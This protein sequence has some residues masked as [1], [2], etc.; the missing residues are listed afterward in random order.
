MLRLAE[1]KHHIAG[2][3]RLQIAPGK[4]DHVFFES[5]RK[6]LTQAPG[7]RDVEVKPSTAVV[8]V[9]Y[10]PA[11]FETFRRSLE[12]FARKDNLFVFAPAG[13]GLAAPHASATRRT[14]QS[15]SSF[16]DHIVQAGTGNLISLKE[17]V[18]LGILAWAL[19]FVDPALAA[20]QWLSWVAFAWAIY[21]DTHQDEPIQE[22]SQQ[23]KALQA[24]MALIRKLLE[25]SL[26]N[27][28]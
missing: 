26:H 12:E 14:I 27:Q 24:D 28:R 21:F 7:V 5:L 17:A 20:S 13:E 18:P 8:I 22:L 25:S 6:H 9:E 19:I 1:Q 2:R 10:D 16:F 11:L 3:L 4:G 15:R 23:L